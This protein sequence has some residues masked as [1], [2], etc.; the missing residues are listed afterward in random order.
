[1]N[2]IEIEGAIVYSIAEVRR[3]IRAQWNFTHCLLSLDNY[4]YLVLQLIQ[5]NS[6]QHQRRRRRYNLTKLRS[7]IGN[8]TNL[9]D[10]VMVT[11]AAAI[12]F[13]NS[14][15]EYGRN[16]DSTSTGGGT[17]TGTT[18][19]QYE[20]E[21]NSLI[22]IKGSGAGTILTNPLQFNGNDFQSLPGPTPTLSRD[23]LIYSK[24]RNTAPIVNEEYKVIF[25]PVAKAA[26]SEWLR[27]FTRLQGSSDWCSN[28]IH[29]H[30]HNQLTNYNREDAQRMM[31]DP[32]WTKAIFVRNPKARL[33]SAFLDKV[34]SHPKIFEQRYCP[35]YVNNGGGTL[36]DC[37]EHYD[38]FDF[39]LKNFT[40]Y[41]GE[42]VHWRSIYSRIDE[43]WWPYI[44][45]VANMEHLD[46]DAKHF[47]QSIRSTKD[48]VSAWD[49]IGKTGWS[50]NE[51]SCDN[52]G[53]GSFL[54]RKDKL[55]HTDASEKMRSY[56]TPEL[57]RYVELKYWK[58]YY[59]PYFHFTPLQLYPGN[60]ADNESERH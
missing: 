45:Y 40:V 36:E 51:R 11:L 33:L 57:E 4:F 59:N 16:S 26:S 58:D 7:K 38:T 55:H 28:D 12:I 52:F 41:C 23:D 1:M 42:N 35:K 32:S 43:Q 56:Y 31:T 13:F 3:V 9:F 30:E 15:Y 54:E 34:L 25:F 21:S 48:G 8:M 10:K 44:N 53:D 50:D 24:S 14:I 20:S 17:S 2:M 46:D 6:L 37:L 22:H 27:F 49:R 39:F 47:L 29:Q 18:Y 5:L 19:N 60:E